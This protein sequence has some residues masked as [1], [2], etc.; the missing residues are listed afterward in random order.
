MIASASV[1]SAR[2]MWLTTK[3]RG[4]RRFDDLVSDPPCEL[5]SDLEG[6][7]AGVQARDD[8]HEP[9]QGYRVEEVQP[10]QPGRTGQSGGEAADGQRT[11]V[12]GQDG[13][14]LADLL[15]SQQGPLDL[16]IFD[17]GLDHEIAGCAVATGHPQSCRTRGRSSFA[18]LSLRDLSTQHA[19][20]EVT[21]GFRRARLGVHELDRHPRE[22][23]H[24]GDAAPHGSGAHDPDGA[25]R[26]A[27]TLR[28][29][30]P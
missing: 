11:G 25:Q 12:G 10:D 3:P 26:F 7:A 8:L 4:V 13:V 28:H 23:R 19:D 20:D 18:Q 2:P 5:A 29:L 9:H 15:F 16:G 17:H 6:T 27:L 1:A 14:R 30:S 24:L 21:G 22:N